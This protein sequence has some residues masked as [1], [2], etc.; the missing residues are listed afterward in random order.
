M[1]TKQLLLQKESKETKKKV[2]FRRIWLESSYL[3]AT[4]CMR[5]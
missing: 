4:M 3:M 5:G 1:A 2:G